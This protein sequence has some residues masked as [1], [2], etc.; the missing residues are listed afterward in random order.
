[1]HGPPRQAAGAD[2]GA[3][4]GDS[5]RGLWSRCPPRHTQSDL[6]EAKEEEAEVRRLQAAE[7]DALEE[8][9]FG[10]P[11]GLAA[12]SDVKKVAP[13]DDTDSKRKTEMVEELDTELN[14]IAFDGLVSA[15]VV[16]RDLSSMSEDDRIAHLAEHAPE[17]LDLCDEYGDRIQVPH[18]TARLSKRCRLVYVSTCALYVFRFVP[19]FM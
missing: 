8:D 3:D 4:V 2:A 15:E 16:Q 1:M 12:E 17:L 10:L 5:G 6:A 13:A 11:F 9:D 14:S 7:A 19:V 18:H